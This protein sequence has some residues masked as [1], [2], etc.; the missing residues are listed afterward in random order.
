MSKSSPSS[1]CQL[2]VK[3]RQPSNSWQAFCRLVHDCLDFSS[4]SSPWDDIASLKPT[5]TNRL[6]RHH[7]WYVKV[8][9]FLASLWALVTHRGSHL[10]KHTQGRPSPK[11]HTRSYLSQC[12]T[13][14]SDHIYTRDLWWE[15]KSQINISY[16][17][18]I[19]Q[20]PAE[21]PLLLP[22]F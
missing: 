4:S 21:N 9:L 10:L 3:H 17:F 13:V 11:A 16:K 6:L 22:L 8:K 19:P 2:P 12:S 18:Q 5:L 1:S 15:A 14:S 7:T 20:K